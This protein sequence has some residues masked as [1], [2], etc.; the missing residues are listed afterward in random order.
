M[1]IYTLLQNLYI[2]VGAKNDLIFS[3]L[4]WKI[5]KVSFGNPNLETPQLLGGIYH[6]NQQP[7]KVFRYICHT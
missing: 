2:E 6:K 7:E 5:S 1:T 3:F 4:E